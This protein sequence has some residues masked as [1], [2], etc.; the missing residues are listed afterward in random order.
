MRESIQA[1][2]KGRHY[3]KQRVR[4]RVRGS[5]E[6]PRLSVFRSNKHISAQVIDDDTAQTLVAATDLN[7]D[8]TPEIEGMSGKV[9]RAKAVGLALAEAAKAKG[10]EAVV[11]DRSGYK[12]H[13]RVAALADGAREGGLKL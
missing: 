1:K 3:R 5:A 13:G 10:I 7:L 6:R 9:A 12:Y 2:R 8:S 11:F 4:R